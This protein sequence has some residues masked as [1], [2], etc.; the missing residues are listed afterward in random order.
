MKEVYDYCN[1][2]H[3]HLFETDPNDNDW[4]FFYYSARAPLKRVL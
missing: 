1:I 2:L 3:I 4:K